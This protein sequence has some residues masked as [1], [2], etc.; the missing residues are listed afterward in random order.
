LLTLVSVATWG[1]ADLGYTAGLGLV[2]ASLHKLRDRW[3]R[4][5]DAAPSAAGMPGTDQS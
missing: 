5:R 3:I 4:I 2:M 1:F